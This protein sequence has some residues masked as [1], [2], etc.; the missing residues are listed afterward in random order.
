MSVS[1]LF[2]WCCSL[3]STGLKWEKREKWVGFWVRGRFSFPI[4]SIPFFLSLTCPATTSSFLICS[5]ETWFDERR[6]VSRDQV[7]LSQCR[8]THHHITFIHTFT[9]TI[10]D[11]QAERKKESWSSPPFFCCSSCCCTTLS[12]KWPVVRGSVRAWCSMSHAIWAKSPSASSQEVRIPLA[13]SEG[14]FTKI[15]V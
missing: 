5:C 9:H 6:E 11:R 3:F 1:L 10:P 12:P 13:P 2:S 4:F 15:R 14:T 7:L 8:A